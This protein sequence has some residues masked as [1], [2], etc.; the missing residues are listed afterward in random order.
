MITA[1]LKALK[2]E[3]SIEVYPALISVGYICGARISS[4]MFAG[5]MLGWFVL[6]PAIVFFGGDSVLFPGT[7]PIP[8]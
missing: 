7:Q 4:Y 2:T 8:V 1:P 5:G 6:I 3:F